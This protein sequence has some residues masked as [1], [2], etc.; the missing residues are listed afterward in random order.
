MPFVERDM[1]LL[2]SFELFQRTA[3]LFGLAFQPRFSGPEFVHVLGGKPVVTWA[4]LS[5]PDI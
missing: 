1:K 5:H 2:Q 4:I 3:K